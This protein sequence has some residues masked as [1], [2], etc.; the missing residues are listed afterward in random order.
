MKIILQ[1]TPSGVKIVDNYGDAVTAPPEL[2][3]HA[4]AS[5]EFDLRS[6]KRKE[7]GELESYIPEAGS[8]TGW[9]F[10]IDRDYDNATLPKILITEGITFSDA[11]GS[12]ILTVPI[13]NTGTR[14]LV[15][16]MNNQAYRKYTAEIGGMDSEARM[17][18]TWQFSIMVKN[19]IYSAET[20]SVPPDVEEVKYYNAMEIKSMLAG[21]ADIENVY[22]KQ[23]VEAM[24]EGIEDEVNSYVDEAILKGAW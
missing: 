7:S 5:L 16:D 18:V 23:E 19:R 17:A 10:A 12:S 20:S 4:S 21:K 9:Y 1:I 8:I 13:A 2:M 14:N 24:M 11:G 6:G 15:E 3:L 22:T